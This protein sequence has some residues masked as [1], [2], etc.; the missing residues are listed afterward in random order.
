MRWKIVSFL[1][2]LTF[3]LSASVVL[4]QDQDEYANSSIMA[5]GP[6]VGFDN[7]RSENNIGLS[8]DYDGE[9][10]KTP[11]PRNPFKDGV[12]YML[13][14]TQFGGPP[15]VT[16]SGGV[17][18]QSAIIVLD[19]KTMT[20]I[21]TLWLGPRLAPYFA[22]SPDLKTFHMV[23]RWNEEVVA[24]DA[25]TGNEVASVPM[26]N[27][28]DL[29]LSADGRTLYVSS[30]QKVVAIDTATYSIIKTLSFDT[31]V[32]G[33]A[34]SWDDRVL[35]VL[36]VDHE[37]DHVRPPLYLIN[38][39]SLTL[40][41]TVILTN[42][43]IMD[44]QYMTPYDLVFTDTGL[45]I[46]WDSNR[47]SFYQVDVEGERQMMEAIV[48]MGDD[49]QV[50]SSSCNVIHYS[51][52]T[53]HAYVAKESKELAI[54]DP[55]PPMGFLEGHFDG[56][57]VTSGL[58]TDGLGVVVSEV[59]WNPEPRGPDTLSI[60][61]TRNHLF[62]YDFYELGFD[63]LS[64]QDMIFL[65]AYMGK[66]KRIGEGHD[67]WLPKPPREPRVPGLLRPGI[68]PDFEIEQFLRLTLVPRTKSVRTSMRI[69]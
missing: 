19:L 26:R 69:L 38:P 48:P 37:H 46:I 30:W 3:L 6:G 5:R 27:L 21:K 62:E 59:H 66:P 58:T 9:P 44:N 49:G 31:P 13:M 29:V 10:L 11:Q 64:V 24:I 41:A 23:D 47:D 50:W 57:P 18:C 20:P 67:H 40:R 60:F 16:C 34:L 14:N 51:E 22:I 42:P 55:S 4:A 15:S 52:A 8:I 25:E 33:M 45:A 39:A 7:A 61:D 2:A 1:I 36:G 65:D 12:L 17:G 56:W 43:L 53:G 35:G 32:T 68:D 63:N 54:Y 28:V